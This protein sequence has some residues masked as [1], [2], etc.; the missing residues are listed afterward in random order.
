M[1]LSKCS[2]RLG[3]L[4][5]AQIMDGAAL[6][7]TIQALPSN[8]TL[9]ESVEPSSHNRH[10]GAPTGPAAI[11]KTHLISCKLIKPE[12][13]IR[14]PVANDNRSPSLSLIHFSLFTF[15]A[16]DNVTVS[17]QTRTSI[18]SALFLLSTFRDQ[19]VRTL[20]N[21]LERFTSFET[22]R[23]NCFSQ[24]NDR[25]SKQAS[26]PTNDAH[27]KGRIFRNQT[28]A[29]IESTRTLRQRHT[30]VRTENESTNQPKSCPPQ[31]PAPRTSNA[32]S[33]RTSAESTCTCIS[34]PAAPNSTAS[35]TDSPRSSTSPTSAYNPSSSQPLSRWKTAP[36]RA[37][38]S[39]PWRIS[40]A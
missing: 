25:A 35:S 15:D 33:S 14:N 5:C 18:H 13:H 6:L 22:T 9:I 23:D 7:T 24:T 4:I 20:V 40:A 11:P 16:V 28:R 27:R 26:K 30:P 29:N 31:A 39:K 19:E 36:T 12:H 38:R 10:S 3:N 34:A 32:P 37:L 21:S 1:S 8:R 17:A 2:S